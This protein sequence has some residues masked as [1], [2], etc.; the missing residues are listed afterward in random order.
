MMYMCLI[1]GDTHM[2]QTCTCTR[3]HNMHKEHL[4]QYNATM[5]S[6]ATKTADDVCGDIYTSN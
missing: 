2:V 5:N 1:I 4:V 6:E 3:K